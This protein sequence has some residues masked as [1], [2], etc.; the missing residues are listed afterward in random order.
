M[1][2]A[3]A[4]ENACGSCLSAHHH[5]GKNT[6]KLSDEELQQNRQFELPMRT[7]TRRS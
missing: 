1:A 3:V 5:M 4:E 2:A 7:T 6:A